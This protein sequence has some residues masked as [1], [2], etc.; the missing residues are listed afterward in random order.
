MFE[1]I[2]TD[3]ISSQIAISEV[4]TQVFVEEQAVPYKLDFDGLDN[5]AVHWLA[6][7]LQ[8]KPVGTARLL[9]DGHLGRMAVLKDFRHQGIGTA[10]LESCIAYAKTDHFNRLYLHAQ[11]TAIGF[12]KKQGFSAYGQQFMDANIPHIAMQLTV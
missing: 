8:G 6:V 3:W 7:T 10:I 4:R 12:Y 11:L 2:K 5:T 1:V 9:K